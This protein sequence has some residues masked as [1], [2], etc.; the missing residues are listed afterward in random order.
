MKRVSFGKVYIVRVVEWFPFFARWFSV[1]SFALSMYYLFCCRNNEPTWSYL[2]Q[3]AAELI[4]PFVVYIISPIAKPA[5]AASRTLSI[6]RT[7]AAS[8]SGRRARSGRWCRGM[9]GRSFRQSGTGITY[10]LA[11]RVHGVCFANSPF[12]YEWN[13]FS[14][15][16]S[17]TSSPEKGEES[18]GGNADWSGLADVYVLTM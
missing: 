10:T 18:C 7:A 13:K 6:Q 9:P 12:F 5:W 14:Y 3:W 17:L 8:S 4:T 2:Q 11:M 1:T 16:S 15:G